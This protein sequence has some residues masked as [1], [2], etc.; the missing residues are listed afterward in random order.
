MGYSGHVTGL[1][2]FLS[3]RGH[4]WLSEGGSTISV[5]SDVQPFY[6]ACSEVAYM[7]DGDNFL[8]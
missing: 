7:K 2:G 4:L 6:G 3:H 1:D 5:S 8:N